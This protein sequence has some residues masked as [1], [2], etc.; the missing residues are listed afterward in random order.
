MNNSWNPNDPVGEVL[1]PG[2][3]P[4]QSAQSVNPTSPA[5]PAWQPP[6]IAAFERKVAEV[7][8][9]WGME[10]GTLARELSQPLQQA[11]QWSADANAFITEARRWGFETP[12]QL[13]R[14]LARR[15]RRRVG[16][17]GEEVI[18]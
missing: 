6:H 11:A 18:E 16:S 3:S 4:E 5:A 10:P 13:G 2:L 15:D 14:L 9:A 12:E 7:E 17:T 1:P 8:A